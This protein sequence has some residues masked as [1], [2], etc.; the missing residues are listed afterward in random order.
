MKWYDAPIVVIDLETT[1]FGKPCHIVE[2]GAVRYEV[3]KEVARLEL[4]MRPPIPIEVGATKTHGLRDSD[5]E[6]E[7]PFPDRYPELA[8]F[9]KGAA[10]ASY[11]DYD[12]RILHEELSRLPNVDAQIPAFSLDWGPWLDVL[13]WARRLHPGPRR[14][15]KHT[16]QTMTEKYGIEVA[17][18]HRALDD[19]IAVAELLWLWQDRLPGLSLSELLADQ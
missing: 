16:L 10:P 6:D 4:L 8:E 9:L 13:T 1:G 11:G 5:V 18:E 2:F 19:A 17:R 12:Q 7:P 14:I 15:G 3:G